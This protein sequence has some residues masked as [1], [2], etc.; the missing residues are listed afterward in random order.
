MI[1]TDKLGN[2]VSCC[3]GK[4]IKGHTFKE[5]RL[6]K[7]LTDIIYYFINKYFNSEAIE[8]LFD[9]NYKYFVFNHVSVATNLLITHTHICFSKNP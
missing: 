6:W 5:L 4:K 9:H 2:R 3:M 1:T 8:H 7:Y